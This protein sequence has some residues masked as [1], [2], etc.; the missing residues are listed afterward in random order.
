MEQINFIDYEGH[1]YWYEYKL[2][3]DQIDICLA[4]K[5]PNKYCNGVF[6]YST[7]D[8]GDGKEFVIVKTSNPNFKFK[9]K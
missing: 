7:K 3:K 6:L 2:A 8:A 4:T 1:R 5:D 9:S